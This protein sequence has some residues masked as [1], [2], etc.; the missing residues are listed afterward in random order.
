MRILILS[1]M[2]PSPT[3]HI[4]GT[5]V[6]QQAKALTAL[7]HD[8]KVVSPLPW[9]PRWSALLAK[10]AK[11]YVEV[12]MRY[13]LDG[14]EVYFPRY[15]IFPKHMF[16]E[17]SGD[18]YYN[19][20][21]SMIA[22]LYSTWPFDIIHAHVALPDGY[23]GVKLKNIYNKPL[24]ITVHGQDVNYTIHRNAASKAKVTQALTAA[25]AVVAVSSMLKQSLTAFVDERKIEIIHNGIDISIVEQP[26]AI[27]EKYIDKKIIV[28][29]GNLL[30][31]KGQ[32]IVIK[33]LKEILD[34]HK[35]VVYIIVG[36]GPYREELER[37]VNRLELHPY[38]EFT[39]QLQHDKAM[40]YVQ[41]CDIFAL[42]SYPEGF[43][44]AFVEA[45]AYGK[46]VI[47]CKGTG[48]EDVIRNGENGLLVE[49]DNVEAVAQSICRL[50]DDE[51]YAQTIG[52]HAMLSIDKLTW[53]NNAQQLDQLYER[54]VQR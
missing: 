18:W 40:E 50:L 42:P 6:H 13:S 11:K 52:R 12:P 44:I 35:D 39:G 16:F 14:I 47:A 24:I 5:F 17:Y 28:S 23:A 53:E 2:Y 41:A 32:H 38:V 34:G 15:I 49:P 43:G 10:R 46:A 7:G 48:I 54:V 22:Q 8:V 30:K 51:A 4:S 36:K 19:A 3:N 37:L 9:M 27:K 29:V 25:D 26:K 33:A 20:I 1:H 31:S 21:K 45:M